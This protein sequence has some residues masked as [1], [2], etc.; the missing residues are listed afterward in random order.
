MTG[1]LITL[2]VAPAYEAIMN[3]LTEEELF[4][5]VEALSLVSTASAE[6]DRMRTAIIRELSIREAYIRGAKRRHPSG[7][8][9]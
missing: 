3:A 6:N 7:G 4:A 5:L 9:T 1:D 8:S 2:P